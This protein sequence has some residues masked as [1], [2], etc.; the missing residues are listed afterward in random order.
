L[1]SA[2]SSFHFNSL[3]DFYA[4]ANQ[5]SANGNAPSTTAFRFITNLDILPCHAGR[6]FTSYKSDKLDLY[7]KM[8]LRVN[9]KFKSNCW[10]SCFR[11]SFAKHSS[12][13]TAVTAMTLEMARNLIQE[14]CLILN[15][16]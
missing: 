12:R 1:F 13:N 8:K 7:V 6:A 10:S 3:S 2:S 4:A 9:D 5:S 14:L 15:I 11:V 16:Y